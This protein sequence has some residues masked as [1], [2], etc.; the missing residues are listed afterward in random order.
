M[1]MQQGKS[2]PILQNDR[3]GFVPIQRHLSGFAP[4]TS[5][6]DPVTPSAQIPGYPNGQP[7][8]SDEATVLPGG[9]GSLLGAALPPP[10]EAPHGGSSRGNESDREPGEFLVASPDMHAAIALAQ[11]LQAQGYRVLRRT[12]FSRL[13]L[14]LSAIGLPQ[15]SDVEDVLGR[16]RQ[17]DSR[18]WVDANQRYHLL[19]GADEGP[20]LRQAEEL[21]AWPKNRKCDGEHLRIGML[22]SVVDATKAGLGARLESETLL[23]NGVPQATVGH[24]TEVAA[25]LAG[26]HGLLPRAQL[27]AANVFRARGDSQDTTAELIL[28]GLDWLLEKDVPVI[29]LSLGGARNLIVELALQRVM[30]QGVAV[31]AAAGNGGPNASPVYPA[32][33]QGVLAV[34]AVDLDRQVYRRANHGDYVDLAAL[35]VD[36]PVPLTTGLIYRTGTSFAAPFVSAS[37]A[38]VIARD[39][40]A[41]RAR[42]GLLRNALDLGEPGPDR[43]FGH[44]LLRAPECH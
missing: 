39:G 3:S 26:S 42:R 23:S 34:T 40:Q 32:A 41:V 1:G 5:V 44:G 18:L 27:Y 12:N 30:A 37:L 21:L 24:G 29:N 25:I 7:I 11:A 10:P 16:L 14:V 28:R 13:G 22:D 36:V 15:G 6:N 38:L 8:P 9:G 2:L 19:A 43:I 31:V 33:Q 4:P 35:G 17:A 20:L